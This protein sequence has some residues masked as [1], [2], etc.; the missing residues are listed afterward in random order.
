MPPF[1]RIRTKVPFTHSCGIFR[2]WLIRLIISQMGLVSMVLNVLKYS[3]G[4]PSTPCD[5][6]PW[7]RRFLFFLLLYSPWWAMYVF[8]FL[9]V[10]GSVVSRSCGFSGSHGEFVLGCF[11]QWLGFPNSAYLR[12]YVLRWVC[13]H[14][15][16]CRNILPIFHIA[17]PSVKLF[18]AFGVC[19]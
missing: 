9:V 17:S 14:V 10:L 7:D 15:L 12:L 16:V 2:P 11:H 8:V 4:I 18:F 1:L 13:F 3:L 19:F 5:F 6:C